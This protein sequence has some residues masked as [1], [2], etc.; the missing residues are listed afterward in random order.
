MKII[1]K[2][3]QNSSNDTDNINITT[4]DL[5][6]CEILLRKNNNISDNNTIY[7]KQ[8]E[9]SQEYA[10][11]PKIEYDVYYKLF[12]KNLTKLNKSICE[13]VNV[14]LSIPIEIVDNIDIFNTKS[15]YYNDICY[16][17]TSDDGTD[18]IL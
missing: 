18:I 16:P 13:D 2:A 11:I 8:I 5:T 12:G 4:L 9:V 17:A 10:K 14:V 15:R 1:L 7:L 3:V 6:Q